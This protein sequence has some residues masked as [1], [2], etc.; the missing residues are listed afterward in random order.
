MLRL[1]LIYLLV[2]AGAAVSARAEDESTHI[3]SRKWGVLYYLVNGEVAGSEFLPQGTKIRCERIE[4]DFCH[5]THD[6]KP[7]FM[8]L[9]H[10]DG[11]ATLPG[12]KPA[13][14]KDQ[15]KLS[16]REKYRR[17]QEAK[18]LVE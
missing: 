7:A 3:V 1:L 11:P 18:G 12:T 14:A 13:A 2:L 15:P 10:L 4:D 6:G 16:A 5:F 8:R 17:A 9:A